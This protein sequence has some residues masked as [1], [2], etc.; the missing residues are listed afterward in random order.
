MQYILFVIL[1]AKL[2]VS[3]YNFVH[4]DDELYRKIHDYIICIVG[5]KMEE[6]N[7]STAE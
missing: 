6:D 3:I 4:H 1:N 2:V 5:E 7:C